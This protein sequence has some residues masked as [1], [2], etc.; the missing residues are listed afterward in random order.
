[1][2]L[3][4]WI[5][6]N[7]CC[8]LYKRSGSQWSSYYY[9]WRAYLDSKRCL[10]GKSYNGGSEPKIASHPVLVSYPLGLPSGL[11]KRAANTY[12]YICLPSF[13]A[14]PCVFNLI[15]KHI[16]L[17]ICK[18]VYKTWPPALWEE[19]RLRVFDNRVLKMIFEHKR[20]E[21]TEESSYIMR[22]FMICAAPPILLRWSCRV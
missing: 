20:N 8:V 13:S 6:L 2:L 9:S 22:S 14:E 4:R 5:E 12:I 7:V 17:K 18:S 10:L 16:K 1:M 11:S 21:L 3:N 15:S 19:H